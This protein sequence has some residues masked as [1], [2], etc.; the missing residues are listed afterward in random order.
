MSNDPLS[1]IFDQPVKPGLK[2]LQLLNAGKDDG[3]VNVLRDDDKHADL[4][5]ILSIPQA[6]I[7]D[8]STC[9]PGFVEWFESQLTDDCYHSINAFFWRSNSYSPEAEK[10]ALI[11]PRNNKPLHKPIIGQGKT[12]VLRWLNAAYV[13]LDIYD[14]GISQG[15]AFKRIIDMMDAKKIPPVSWVKNSGQGLWLFWALHPTR[16]YKTKTE[17]DPLP[18]YKRIL[19]QLKLI[20]RDLCSDKRAVDAARVSRIYGSRNHKS[21]T[22]V[23][24]WQRTDAN[25]N[26]ARYTLDELEV[27]FGT[28]P[29]RH[30]FNDYYSS[31]PVE[32]TPEQQE[33][34][35]QQEPTEH[36]KRIG[37]I[38]HSERYEI[39]LVRFWTLAEVVRQKKIKKGSRNTHVAILAA[40]LKHVISNRQYDPKQRAEAIEA[41]AVRIWECFEDQPS[42]DLSSVKEQLISSI[43]TQQEYNPD[44]IGINI[45]HQ[46]IA[47]ELELTTAEAAQLAD[48]VQ[49]RRKDQFWPPA[50]G[51]A[52]FRLKPTPRAEQQEARRD[53]LARWYAGK[54]PPDSRT[55][56][57][58]ITKATGFECSHVTALKDWKAVFPSK[59]DHRQLSFL[60]DD[61]T[62]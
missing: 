41:A 27:F 28:Y 48:L 13:D 55:L 47:N 38:G 46:T 34:D 20:F 9:L 7:N 16:S 39:D 12:T 31:A 49:A 22:L 43:E 23:S 44:A 57:A 37:Y 40:I 35:E 32:A 42:Y 4:V 15:E 54:L 59:P 25:G 58:E 56:A 50:D 3:F 6:V 10:Y 45:K 62:E 8:P 61:E 53:F 17:L 33:P 11:D 18:Q 19:Q 14:R 29:R 60:D 30:R 36:R 24:L 5:P 51:Q 1:S 21:Q 52:P 26:M 2:E